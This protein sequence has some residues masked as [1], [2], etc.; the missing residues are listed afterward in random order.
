MPA[1]V[2]E[3]SLLVRYDTWS[4]WREAKIAEAERRRNVPLVEIATVQCA[5]C[6]GQRRI[7]SPAANGEGLVPHPCPSCL[8]RG[9]I[10]TL[11]A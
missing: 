1:L 11:P 9:Y 4:Q 3:D 5:H 7:F 8:G 2:I 6:W 10:S